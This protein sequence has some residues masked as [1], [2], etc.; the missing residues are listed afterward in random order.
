MK[1]ANVVRDNRVLQAPLEHDQLTAVCRHALGPAA[2]LTAAERVTSGGFNTT[3]RLRFAE[4]APLIL[5]I[6]PPPDALL[7]RHE[8][9]LLQ[10]ECAVQ[11][12]LAKAS[13]LVPRVV[14]R[15]F[16]YSLLPRAYVLQ[17]TFSKEEMDSV[18]PS[19]ISDA[20][21]RMAIARTRML[22]T[23]KIVLFMHKI[24]LL[25]QWV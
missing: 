22:Q 16:S 13:A 8:M 4:G 14:F 11:P 19:L 6:A 17:N 10:R 23:Q 5:R 21:D 2:Q 18:T 15:D 20:E 24:A 1:F 3:Y 7:F 25:Q 9:M 12:L